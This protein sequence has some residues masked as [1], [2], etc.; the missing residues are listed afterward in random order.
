MFATPHLRI[1]TRAIIQ[2]TV[3]PVPVPVA[4]LV[5]LVVTRMDREMEVTCLRVINCFIECILQ[6]PVE[7][8]AEVAQVVTRTVR[9]QEVRMVH[10]TQCQQKIVYRSGRCW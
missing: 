6:A 10:F 7:T 3:V 1:K 8:V 2:A 5:A 9:A 4:A